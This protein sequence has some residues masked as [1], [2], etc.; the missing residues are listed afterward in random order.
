MTVDSVAGTVATLMSIGT[1]LAALILWIMRAIIRDEVRP[2]LTMLHE[3][4]AGHREQ[5]RRLGYV[6]NEVARLRDDTSRRG[7]QDPHGHA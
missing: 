7:C 4:Q 5:D 3:L 6:E 2:T 1:V